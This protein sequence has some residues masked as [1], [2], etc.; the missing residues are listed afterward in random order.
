MNRGTSAR[1]IGMILTLGL[2]GMGMGLLFGM[3]E[4]SRFVHDPTPVFGVV[5]GAAIFFALLRGPVGRA[6]AKMLEGGTGH[7]DKLALRVDD[8]EAQLSELGQDQ[9]RVAEL[10]DR[11]DFAE[12]VLAQ[13]SETPALR[14][15]EPR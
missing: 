13:R 15:P 5:A 11:L 12:R 10:E 8:L 6:I 4:E 9:R 2:M 14:G 3:I 7:D 1:I